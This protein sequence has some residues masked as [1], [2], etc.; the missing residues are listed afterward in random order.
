MFP[1]VNPK[2]PG[3]AGL[4]SIINSN[5]TALGNLNSIP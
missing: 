1:E 2:V 5:I 4:F 3:F